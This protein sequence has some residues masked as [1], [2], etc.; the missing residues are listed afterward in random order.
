MKK[1]R[2]G[3]LS[4]AKI[5]L[6]KVIPAMQSGRYTEVT[7]IASR[8]IENAQ[9]AASELHIPQIHET[10]EALLA[11]PEIDAVYI[12]LPNHLHI[13]WTIEA[14]KAGKHVLCE[15]PIGLDTNEVNQLIDATSR[16]PNLK[17][18]EAFMYRHHPQWVE[19]KR[20]IKAGE[21][22][23]F[24]TLQS[25]FS[26]FNTDPENIRNKADIG[27]GGLMDIGCYNIS[28]SRFLFDAEPKRVCGFMNTDAKF[29][30]DRLFSGMLDFSGRISTFTCATQ[31]TAYQ[32][33]NILGTS[34]RIEIL[35]PFNAPPN[36]PTQIILQRD[37]L[38]DEEDKLR[39][40]TFGVSDQYTLQGDLFAKS[41]LDDTPVPTPLT[42]AWA[43]M[44][45]LEAL[46]TSAQSNQWVV[47]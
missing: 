8:S 25:F 39:T 16:Y 19:A 6:T 13:P 12:P 34:G 38:E 32:R 40:I 4:T 1:I 41:I 35:I 22:G 21:I 18:M 27:G 10:Y 26:Y 43:N 7:A 5:A 23:E 30:T 2:L 31:L 24:I 14:M 28:L 33:V 9:K 3:I 46:F 29:G 20:L 44:H 37:M 11:D 15:K 42:D 47:C 17:V 45:T 36:A